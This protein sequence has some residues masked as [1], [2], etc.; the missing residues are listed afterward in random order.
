MGF[1]WFR[2]LRKFCIATCLIDSR[3]LFFLTRLE[4]SEIESELSDDNSKG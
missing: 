2:I 1:M 3:A 4:L